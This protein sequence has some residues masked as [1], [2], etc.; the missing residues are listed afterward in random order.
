MQLEAR[1]GERERIARELHDTLLQGVQG[2]ILRVHAATRAIPHDHP[3][4]LSMERAVDKAEEILVEGR[5]RLGELRAETPSHFDLAGALAKLV[6]EQQSSVEFNM[7]VEG[8]VRPLTPEAADEI[9]LIGREAIVN[10]IR[11]ADAGTITCRLSYSAQGLEFCI[12]DNGKGIDP[13]IA[14]E[15]GREGHFGLAGMR[16]RAAMLHGHL[17]IDTSEAGGTRVTL[18]VPG[19]IA[20][21]RRDHSS[22]HREPGGP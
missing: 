19:T 9:Y 7:I 5:D 17:S 11:H 21:A 15:K 6:D 14:L 4:R 10:A 20:Y 16:E 22:V 2:L 1:H 8:L 18:G 13:A 12:Q 3:A